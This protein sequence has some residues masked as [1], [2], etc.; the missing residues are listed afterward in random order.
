M[1]KF[2]KPR[3]SRQVGKE[4]VKIVIGLRTLPSRPIVVKGNGNQFFINFGKGQTCFVPRPEDYPVLKSLILRD[5]IS[6]E[7]LAALEE[8][9]SHMPLGNDRRA[10]QR[11]IRTKPGIWEHDGISSPHNDAIPTVAQAEQSVA[12]AVAPTTPSTSMDCMK[13]VSGI[14]LCFAIAGGI[15]YGFFKSVKQN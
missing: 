8:A 12:N 13:V 6:D 10:K 2:T 9:K 11:R 15:G 4:I 7:Q 5:I 14:L 3:N 1:K